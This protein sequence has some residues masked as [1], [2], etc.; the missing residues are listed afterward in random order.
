M[1]R[2][3][4][5]TVSA[6]AGRAALTMI[7]ALAASTLSLADGIP[8]A[9]AQ[10]VMAAPGVTVDMG[11]LDDMGPAQTVPDLLFPSARAPRSRL[12]VP[13]AGAASGTAQR[14]PMLP[15][16]GAMPQSRLQ[17][18][19]APPRTAPT[20]PAQTM[21]APRPHQPPAQAVQ[22][23]A[24]TVASAPAVVKP[25]VP[26]APPVTETAPTPTSA[27]TPAPG[28]ATP[29]PA[30]PAP[31]STSEPRT[32]EPSSPPE[33]PA[34]VAALPAPPA[35]PP[36]P[37]PA[38]AEAAAPAA[39]PPALRG[40]NL[41]I[42]FPAGGSDLPGAAKPQ[43]DA[44]AQRLGKEESLQVRVMAYAADDGENASRARRTS[45]SRAL[46]VRSALMDHGV[47]A[48]R[49]EVRA[50]GQPASGAPDRVDVSVLAP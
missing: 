3:M 11:V 16:P 40:D 49:I 20:Q 37:P 6:A 42:P 7:A 41:T 33:M 2:A 5:R 10:S 31:V 14:Q 23:P 36:V 34:S 21:A 25:P 48:N 9:R 29:S 45:L 47:N 8:A 44:L 32:P 39:A 12:L 35:A 22:P 46:A 30:A 18:P 19:A 28:A 43:L 15:T 4:P 13:P 38:A 1:R 24:Q 27:P 50:L 17:V 26:A